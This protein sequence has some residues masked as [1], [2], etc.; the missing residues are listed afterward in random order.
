[1]T[2]E[3]SHAYLDR[4]EAAMHHIFRSLGPGVIAKLAPGL[5]PPQFVILRLLSQRGEMTVSELAQTLC[6]KPSAVTSITDR[7]TGRGQVTRVRDE[8][9]DRRLVWIRLTDDGAA[10]IQEVEAKRRAMMNHYLAKLSEQEIAS[11]VQSLE[12]F[13]AV[14][15]DQDTNC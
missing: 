12:R 13:A 1:M 15:P 4:M 10:L 3:L 8:V 2:P 11:L 5:T 7:L 9:R 6:V 14:V